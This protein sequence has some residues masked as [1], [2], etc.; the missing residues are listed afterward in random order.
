MNHTR[1]NAHII[2]PIHYIS[3]Q[4]HLSFQNGGVWSEALILLSK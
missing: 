1:Q 4:P 2:S 3:H